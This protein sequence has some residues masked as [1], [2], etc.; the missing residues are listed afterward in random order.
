MS[1]LETLS[2]PKWN[3][4]GLANCNLDD[5]NY[6]LKLGGEGVMLRRNR[7]LYKEGRSMDL[8]KLKRFQ[9]AE[10]VVEGYEEGQNLIGSLVVRMGDIVFKIGSGL[11][12]AI[13]SNPPAIG[14]SVTFRFFELTD[15]G[16]PRFPTF[17]AVRDYE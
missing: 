13:R 12:D 6:F 2:K 4:G 17:L 11:N 15:R 14:A 16:C 9:T 10:A 3:L 5:A 7:S 8:L 1:P